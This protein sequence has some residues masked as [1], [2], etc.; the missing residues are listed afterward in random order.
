MK[1]W[2]VWSN[3]YYEWGDYVHG[4][5]VSKAKSM[6]WKAWSYETEE[7]INMR[8]QRIPELDNIPLTSDNIET[9]IGDEFD[10]WKSCCEC[11]LCSFQD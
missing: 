5:T 11:F 8:C 2:F 9:I 7:W 6:F 4:E 10:R 1:A 3:P